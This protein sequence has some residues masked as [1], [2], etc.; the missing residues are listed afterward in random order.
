[1]APAFSPD[2]SYE[3]KMVYV[4]ADRTKLLNKKIGQK[5]V[6]SDV[7]AKRKLFDLL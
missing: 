7:N 4:E 1:M 3:D 6:E 2:D 5:A